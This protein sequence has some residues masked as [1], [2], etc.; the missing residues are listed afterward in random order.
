MKPIGTRFGLLTLTEIL[1]SKKKTGKVR[2]ICACGRTVDTLYC[3]L[4][5]K[6]ITSCGQ[7]DTEYYYRKIRREQLDSPV[8]KTFGRLKVIREVYDNP[9]PKRI[10]E[11]LCACGNITYV[12]YGNLKNNLSTSCGCYRKEVNHGIA[13]HGLSKTRLYRIWAGMK[14]RCYN[15]KNKNYM[16]YGEQG[17]IVSEEWH[18]DFMKFR[19]WAINNGY[20]EDLSIDR[21]NPFGNYEPSNCRWAT[22]KEQANNKR[23]NY[24]PNS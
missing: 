1:T 15:P 14:D 8:G 19:E 4:V 13:T 22:A 20:K 24:K 5:N 12:E 21:I 3:K 2:C 7:C 11:C 23:S 10:F 18:N 9:S 16:Y 6:V 17:V